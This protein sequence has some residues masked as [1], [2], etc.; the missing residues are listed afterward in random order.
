MKAAQKAVLQEPSTLQVVKNTVSTIT[1]REGFE[2]EK[3]SVDFDNE[4]LPR[5]NRYFLKVQCKLNG[6]GLQYVRVRGVLLKEVMYDDKPGLM[7]VQ[8]ASAAILGIVYPVRNHHFHPP[9][10]S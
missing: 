7:D 5:L 4:L 1:G 9:I 2:E 8:K 6:S 10:C 3:S